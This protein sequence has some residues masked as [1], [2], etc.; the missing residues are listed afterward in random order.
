MMGTDAIDIAAAKKRGNIMNRKTGTIYPESD[1]W[2]DERHIP[3]PKEY[4][5]RFWEISGH[6]LPD[7]PSVRILYLTERMYE[8]I[9]R[10][11][12]NFE[13]VCAGITA[14]QKSVMKDYETAG[15]MLFMIRDDIRRLSGEDWH[16]SA[17]WF[18]PGRIKDLK[19]IDD[20]RKGKGVVCY[21]FE[22]INRLCGMIAE[23]VKN[24]DVHSAAGLA[25]YC[26][27]ACIM[28]YEIEKKM[29]S[30]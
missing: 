3:G 26:P 16:A 18:D 29:V 2:K 13:E 11:S 1:I 8:A 5:N 19:M 21:V 9:A 24:G 25:Y 12:K 6:K 27:A 17:G 30:E 10:L 23:A 7:F 22:D 20:M 4:R 14:D 15:V 28:L